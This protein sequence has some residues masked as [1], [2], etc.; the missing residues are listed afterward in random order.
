MCLSKLLLASLTSLFTYPLSAQNTAPI[1]N[2]V[3]F[4]QRTDGSGIV[5]VYYDVSDDHNA[6]M[7]ISMQV[8]NDYGESWE[9]IPTH[10]SGDI[11]EDIIPGPGK[12]I[13]WNAGLENYSLQESDQY[14]FKVIANDTISLTDFDGNVYE[15][16]W[17]GEELW[18][19]DNMKTTHYRNGVEIPH[20]TSSGTWEATTAG[21]YCDFNNDPANSEIYG[22]MYNWF[23]TIDNNGICPEGWHVPTSEEYIWLFIYL[24]GQYNW[25]DDYLYAG[26]KLKEIGLDHWNNPNTGATNESGFTALP[27]GERLPNGDYHG[28]WLG[29]YGD[30]LGFSSYYW[31]SSVYNNEYAMAMRLHYSNTEI[32]WREFYKQSGYSIRCK[33][34]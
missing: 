33:Q 26:G 20:V 30:G 5:D 27:G 3:N 12:H 32:F 23:T 10:L 1:V 17:I 15:T 21:A 28:H 16:V 22:R 29:W 11:G 25:D 31:S 8:S 18:M 14:R 4:T 2:N 6:G 9:I 24:G 7:L 13:I 19:A 34:N